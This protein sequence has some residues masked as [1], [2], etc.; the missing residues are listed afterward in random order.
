M[1]GVNRLIGHTPGDSRAAAL[2]AERLRLLGPQPMLEVAVHLDEGAVVG[3]AGEQALSGEADAV[4]RQGPEWK[5]GWQMYCK[6][7]CVTL[8]PRF[9]LVNNTQVQCTQVQCETTVPC[10]R[11]LICES[12]R[13]CWGL[14]LPVLLDAAALGTSALPGQD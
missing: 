10:A 11:W 7:R 14:F 9:T 12:L 13:C 8:R 6:T 1:C 2:D 4:P 3:R 5:G